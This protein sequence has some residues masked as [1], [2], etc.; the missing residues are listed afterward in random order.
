[1]SKADND[2]MNALHGHLARMLT[3]AIIN[4]VVEIDKEGG[5]QVVAAP[6]SILSVARQFLKDNNI[7]AD[8]K[9]SKTLQGLASVLPFAGSQ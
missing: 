8:L 2:E 4:G 5:K 7:E 1:M 3:T 9:K 6:A